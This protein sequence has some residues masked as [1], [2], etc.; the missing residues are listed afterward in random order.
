MTTLA[1]PAGIEG[2]PAAS[3]DASPPLSSS[4]ERPGFLDHSRASRA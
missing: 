4:E 2:Q 1:I 3:T